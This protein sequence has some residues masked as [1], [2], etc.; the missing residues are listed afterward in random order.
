VSDITSPSYSGDKCSFSLGREVMSERLRYIQLG[1][2]SGTG[3]MEGES[4]SSI[5]SPHAF[6][7]MCMLGKYMT[8]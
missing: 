6:Y 7:Y 4:D 5:D 8:R 2:G 1:N 3:R